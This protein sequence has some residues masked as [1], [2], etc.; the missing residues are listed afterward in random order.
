MLHWL[1]YCFSY[2]ISCLSI[3]YSHKNT[4]HIGKAHYSYNTSLAIFVSNTCHPAPCYLNKDKVFLL[5]SNQ[6]RNPERGFKPGSLSECLFEFDT[7]SKPL[8]ALPPRPVK[9]IFVQ[10]IS[11]FSKN[12]TWISLVLS[13]PGCIIQ[14]ILVLPPFSIFCKSWNFKKNIFFIIQWLK[15][16]CSQSKHNVKCLK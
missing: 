16:A 5:L 4:S 10:N 2:T 15:Q 3:S 9:D 6:Y 11:Y 8:P 13:T 1:M 7:R 12:Y 14:S